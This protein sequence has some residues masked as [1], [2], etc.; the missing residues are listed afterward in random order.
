MHTKYKRHTF[1]IFTRPTPTYPTILNPMF[2]VPPTSNP[3]SLN[4]IL[5]KLTD[6]YKTKHKKQS[7][8]NTHMLQ[9]HEKNSQSKNKRK[10]PGT[11]ILV[12]THNMHKSQSY[13][14]NPRYANSQCLS[15]QPQPH[16]HSYINVY[17]THSK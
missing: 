6:P 4:T 3:H 17:C 2:T 9:P 10:T 16:T 5:T 11:F 14:T 13:V 7:K 8:P 15:D 1:K 12:Y